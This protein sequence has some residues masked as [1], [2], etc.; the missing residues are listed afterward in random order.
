MKGAPKIAEIGIPAMDGVLFQFKARPS[1]E[2][3]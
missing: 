2:A 1:I 3:F